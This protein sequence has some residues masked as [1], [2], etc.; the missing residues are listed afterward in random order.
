MGT[1]LN[2]TSDA[3]MAVAQIATWGL[4]LLLVAVLLLG[5]YLSRLLRSV[6][7]IEAQLLRSV[8]HVEFQLHHQ[9]QLLSWVGKISA[10]ILEQARN[11]DQDTA[12]ASAGSEFHEG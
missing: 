6:Q 10:L 2:Q 1:T 4:A 12:Q 11:Q 7:H 3:V 8:Q 9:A 5:F